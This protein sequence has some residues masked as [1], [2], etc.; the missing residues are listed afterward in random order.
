MSNINKV[1]T[2]SQ[3]YLDNIDKWKLNRLIE[4]SDITIQEN[5]EQH[6]FYPRKW[7]ES[8]LA[9]TQQ[10]AFID[11]SL[12]HPALRRTISGSL[13]LVFR[14]PMEVVL[15]AKLSYLEDNVNG[16]GDSLV[17]L[18]HDTTYEAQLQGYGLLL[19]DYADVTQLEEESGRKLSV[20]EKR[21]LNA[22]ATIQLYKAESIL[23]VYLKRIGSVTVVDQIVL[24]EFYEDRE[25]QQFGSTTKEQWR[26][27]RLNHEG[28]YEQQIYR[29]DSDKESMLL[30]SSYEPRDATGNRQ[31]KIPAS[32]FGAESNKY[33]PGAS[34]SYDLARMNA[35]HLEY[36]AM[37]GES[38]RQ[39]APTLFADMGQG[40]DQDTFDEEYPEGMILGGFNAYITG[41]GG[42]ATILQ[43]NPNDAA[44]T[45]MAHL[46]EL[47]VQA[48]AL[49]ITPNTS[50][51]S[52]ETS[53]IQR[54]T[55]SSILGMIVR[56]VEEAINE[57]LNY[58]SEYE[59]AAPDSSLVD[60]NRDFFDLPMTAQDRAA[61]SQDMMTGTVSVEEYRIALNK[62]GH[63][64]DSAMESND[65]IIAS[66]ESNE[67]TEVVEEDVPEDEEE[68]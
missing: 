17:Q 39:L 10:K 26:V 58:V 37:R 34:P 41:V 8:Q 44:S 56:N 29:Q 16:N 51:V 36:S 9:K 7:D 24:S 67:P 52:A 3:A 46:E 64:P 27:L 25:G 40:F 53:I 66:I 19:A 1:N 35:K 30:V 23:N 68:A 49:V 62:A 48:G 33:I 43:A 32:F 4:S 61:W 38:I 14:K 47:M 55:D 2:P 11:G 6:L 45:E 21:D 12:L 54:S 5:W 60:I 65:E 20:G 59:G 42:K 28:Y 18:T 15:D 50:N 22:R 63:L 13:G 31:T 57:Q